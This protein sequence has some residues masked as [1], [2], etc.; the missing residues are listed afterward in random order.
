MMG[1]G[2]RGSCNAKAPHTSHPSL[3]SGPH[4]T[5]GAE[6]TISW[7]LRAGPHRD[8]PPAPPLRAN[9]LG[10]SAEVVS[11]DTASVTLAGDSPAGRSR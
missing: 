11:I 4:A 1:N 6:P 8:K 7:I 9:R 3:G 5:G 2:N 10:S